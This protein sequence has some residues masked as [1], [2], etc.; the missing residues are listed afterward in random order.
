MTHDE[1]LREFLAALAERRERAEEHEALS[2]ELD[3]AARRRRE[4]AQDANDQAQ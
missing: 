2:Y 1:D 3:D 4:E